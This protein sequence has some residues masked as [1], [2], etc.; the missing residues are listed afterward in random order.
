MVLH[1]IEEKMRSVAFSIDALGERTVGML[2]H[3]PTL[4]LNPKPLSWLLPHSALAPMRN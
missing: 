4:T 3:I 2:Q 1:E